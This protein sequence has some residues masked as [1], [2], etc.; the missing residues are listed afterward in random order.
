MSVR[1]SIV[2][3][4]SMIL[5][6]ISSTLADTQHFEVI[7]TSSNGEEGLQKFSENIPDILILGLRLP[8]MCAAEDLLSFVVIDSTVPIVIYAEDPGDAEADTTLK[9]GA[10][11]FITS[12][13]T[14]S[15]IIGALLKVSKG[16]RFVPR[17]L[18]EK[19]GESYVFEEL[20]NSEGEVLR[21]I[22]G[23]LS[24][25][26]IAFALDVSD[27]TVKTHVKHIF[28][29]LQVNDRTSASVVAIKRGLVRVDV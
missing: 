23:G 27:N 3:S 4:N 7:D 26:E 11:G 19:I 13:M 20:T 12:D 18:S 22:V 21:M 6:G 15:E 28:E 5:K 25:K 17:S 16:E 8:D 10:S 9:A 29:K 14:E 24:N 1:V 2:V